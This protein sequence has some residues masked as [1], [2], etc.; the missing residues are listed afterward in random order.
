MRF[1]LYQKANVQSDNIYRTQNINCPQFWGNVLIGLTM[2]PL[3]DWMRAGHM[4]KPVFT[5][6]IFNNICL[7]L[8]YNFKFIFIVLSV[9]YKL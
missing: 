9:I 5:L 1:I 8:F 6:Y 4:M 2:D 3:S 7:T